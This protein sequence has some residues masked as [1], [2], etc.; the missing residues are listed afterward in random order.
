MGIFMKFGRFLICILRPLFY[1]LF[2]YKVKGSDNIPEN[3]E[4][5]LI[6]CSNHISNIDPVFLLMAFK[7][8]PIFYM[9]KAELFANK[10]AIWFFQK[11]FGAFPVRRG[12]GDA[13]SLET[14]ERIVCEGKL[15][16]IFPE[17][18][19]SK[20]GKLG[21]VK[22][23]AALIASRTGASIL[24]VAIKTTNQKVALFRKTHI[25]IGKPITPDEL[26]LQDHEK[27]ELRYASRIIMERIA[28]MMEEDA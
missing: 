2:P 22:S 11:Q 18:T 7:S 25:I 4:G 16:G 17:G 27:P 13:A 1:L 5:R 3:N 6:L 26:H 15:M 14:A 23:G 8:R 24:P 12:Q 19:R 21:R 28:K 20:D 9:A 10:L